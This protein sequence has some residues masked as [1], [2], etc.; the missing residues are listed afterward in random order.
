MFQL[1]LL[2]FLAPVALSKSLIVTNNCPYTVWPVISNTE[3]NGGYTGPRGWKAD[4]GDWHTEEIPQTWNGRIWARRGCNFDDNDPKKGNCLAGGCPTDGLEC[5]DNMMGDSNLVE[6]N[7]NAG[8]MGQSLD[9]Y[10]VSAVP[11][12]VVPIT[13]VPGDSNCQS[14]ACTT[15]LNPTCPDDRMKIIDNGE[16]IGCLSACMAGIK[17]PPEVPDSPNCCSGTFLSHEACQPQMVDYYDF[18]KIGCPNAYAYP[19]DEDP[20]NVR[21]PV[22]FTC[23]PGVPW[24][25]ITFC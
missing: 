2:S 14:V 6:M 17:A 4:P 8:S 24:Y 25:R 3:I 20:T 16:T 23:S 12:F 19:R 1:L 21:P 10:D 22:V 7:L 11:G 9:F 18:F 13:L 15:D 5:G